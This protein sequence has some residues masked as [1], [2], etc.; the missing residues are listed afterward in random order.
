MSFT[1][2]RTEHAS[3]ASE[4]RSRSYEAR[5]AKDNNVYHDTAASTP[6]FFI[7]RYHCSSAAWSWDRSSS[8]SIFHEMYVEE[9]LSIRKTCESQRQ[10]SATK[11]Q[12][13][14]SNSRHCSL[15]GWIDRQW[16]RAHSRAASSHGVMVEG[17]HETKT[18]NRRR[19]TRLPPRLLLLL[20]LCPR[21]P[22]AY[23][24]SCPCS[25]GRRSCT[26]PHPLT[27]SCS[28]KFFIWRFEAV[29]HTF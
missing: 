25:C 1:K 18:G 3:V 10:W 4:G 5:L 22:R 11:W 24:S 6:E 29:S 14:T 8:L 26:S 23:A 28:C 27:T 12:R 20:R 19:R 16:G 13:T 2:K 9:L 17:S 15:C 21:C 7:L